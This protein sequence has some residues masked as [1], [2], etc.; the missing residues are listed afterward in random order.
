MSL[1]TLLLYNGTSLSKIL[2]S[3]HISVTQLSSD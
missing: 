1:D 3:E 2:I